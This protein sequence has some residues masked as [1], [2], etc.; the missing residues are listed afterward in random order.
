MSRELVRCKACCYIMDARNLRDVCPACGVKAKMFE[1]YVPR[2][3]EERTRILDLH[4]HGILVHLPQA[5]AVIFLVLSVTLLFLCPCGRFN[6]RVIETMKLLSFAYPIVVLGGMIT[7]IVDAKIRFRKLSAPALRLK[8][9]LGG[10]F[11]LFATAIPLSFALLPGTPL[12]QR[13]LLVFLSV[14]AMVPSAL[15]GKIGAGLNE[16]GFP[17]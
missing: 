13:V 8:I 16:T 6:L 1:P 12:S 10:A 9:I 11:L 17:N 4:L 2:M 14:C 15:L 3:K 7:G 5:F